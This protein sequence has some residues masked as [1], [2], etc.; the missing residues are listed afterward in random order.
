MSLLSQSRD[1]NFLALVSPSGD[2]SVGGGM[3]QEERSPHQSAL[4]TVSG[5]QQ[6][7]LGDKLDTY[8]SGTFCVPVF[9]AVSSHGLGPCPGRRKL[10]TK[11]RGTLDA[12]R[13][14]CES[15]HG[16]RASWRSGTLRTVLLGIAA[17]PFISWVPTLPHTRP[18]PLSLIFP[19]LRFWGRREIIAED[20]L[21]WLIE[22]KGGGCALSEIGL[23][24]S[25]GISVWTC[26]DL[27]FFFL[28]YLV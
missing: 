24:G 20:G 17:P 15:V 25:S 8:V 26:V 10:K 19:P 11:C 21:G 13:W 5:G 4:Q 22:G 7:V 23:L 6:E 28:V 12:I 27:L 1:I 18:G 14:S 2:I 16:H 9:P 3:F